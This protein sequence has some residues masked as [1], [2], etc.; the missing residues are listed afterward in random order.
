MKDLNQE[1]TPESRQYVPYPQNPYGGGMMYP[2]YNPAVQTQVPFFPPQPSGATI[3]TPPTMPPMPGMMMPGMGSPG[4]AP[5][6]LPIEQSYIENL[7]RLNRGKIGTFYFTF[8]NN[9]EWN[10]K[11]ITGR[12]EAAGRDH[13]IISDPETGERYMMLM[14]NF[15]YATFNERL[16]YEYPFGAAPGQPIA[17]R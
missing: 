13:I 11:V 6:M 8:E 4:Q 3:P 2:G 14:V 7:L 12:V 17:P 5:G 16:N 10:A 9:N 15:D 1:F